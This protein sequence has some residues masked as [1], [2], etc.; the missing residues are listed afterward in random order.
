MDGL[1]GTLITN[2]K[3]FVRTPTFSNFVLYWNTSYRHPIRKVE[4]YQKYLFDNMTQPP[5]P[6]PAPAV[7]NSR[8]INDVP[9]DVVVPPSDNLRAEESDSDIESEGDVD[10]EGGF[11]F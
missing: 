4:N 8:S 10:M 2:L 6:A 9:I 3:T 1:S 5:A 7:Y 11:L